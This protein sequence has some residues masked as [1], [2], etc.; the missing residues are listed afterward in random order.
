MP[1]DARVALRREDQKLIGRTRDLSENGIYV[2]MNDLLEQGIQV[3]VIFHLPGRET[4]PVEA[5]GKIAWV[6]DPTRPVKPDFPPGCGI[7][8]T[9]I[10][11]GQEF[12]GEWLREMAAA[13]P[14]AGQTF[15]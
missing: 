15:H 8:F 7:A 12:L 9:Q 11:N 6:N 2:G 5:W 13:P 10:R 3:Q 4:K 14:P 1:C